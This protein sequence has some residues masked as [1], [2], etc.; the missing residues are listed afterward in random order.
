M[1]FNLLSEEN[2]II[3][4]ENDTVDVNRN[5]RLNLIDP[6]DP[7]AQF[8]MH[9]RITIKNSAT[10]YY[11]ALTGDLEPNLLADVYF[12]AENIQIL[13]NGLR[14]GVHKMSQG[15]IIIAPQNIDNLKIIMRS[16]YFQYA[17]HYPKDI[18][19]QVELLNKHVL[20]YAVPSVF[21]EAVAYIKYLKD[22]SSLVVPL[23]LPE[24]TGK[25]HK[26][27][28]LYTNGRGGYE[29]NRSHVGL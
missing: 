11:D 25:D 16:I 22:Q 23:D 17:E 15:K 27:L 4:F 29:A 24:S 20:E 26:H 9:E 18:R 10:N 1:P 14:A 12:S 13:Q 2:P 21:S 5:G 19:G 7:E 3:S 8:K 28:E 6:I